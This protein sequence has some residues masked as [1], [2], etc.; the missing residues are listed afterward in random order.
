MRFRYIE[1][2]FHVFK[3]NWD[4]ENLSLYR[5]LRYTEVRNIKVPLYKLKSSVYLLTMAGSKYESNVSSCSNLPL[6][7]LQDPPS[8]TPKVKG[9]FLS[10]T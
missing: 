1:L 6:T 2:H 9:L 8:Q 10:G 4:K 5:A 7:H 3:Y